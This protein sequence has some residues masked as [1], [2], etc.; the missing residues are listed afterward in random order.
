MPIIKKEFGEEV[1][2]KLKQKGWSYRRAKIATGIDHYT[3]GEMASGVVP[4][5]GAVIDWAQALHENVNKWLVLAGYDPIPE[6]LI[7]EP[8]KRI[9]LKPV[10][11]E[12]QAN[13][14][15]AYTFEHKIEIAFEWLSRECMMGFDGTGE[16]LGMTDKLTVVR[17]YE[18]LAGVPAKVVSERLGHANI[19]I[20]QDIYTHVLPDMQD[21]AVE[22][23][24]RLLN[25]ID[26]NRVQTVHK[27]PKSL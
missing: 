27:T 12:V 13:I 17:A 3:I 6:E 9:L 20:T 1:A 21:A 10:P 8:G 11:P 16:E 25:P 18:M 15:Q 26:Q 14:D 24:E 19:G 4:K 2:E 23:A 7:I 5:K 22:V